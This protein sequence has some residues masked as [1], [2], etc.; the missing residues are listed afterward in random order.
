MKL[1]RFLEISGVGKAMVNGIDEG[2]AQATR[3]DGWVIREAEGWV[4]PR[5][6]D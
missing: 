2:E 4:V 1:L 5:G 6:P 3:L